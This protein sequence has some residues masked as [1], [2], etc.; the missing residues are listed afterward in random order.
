MIKIHATL[1]KKV[2]IPGLDYSSQSYGCGLE[3]EVSDGA[4]HEQIQ[5]RIRDTY[6]LLEGAIDAEIAARQ[7][8]PRGSPGNGRPGAGRFDNAG[9]GSRN[10]GGD[11]SKSKDDRPASKPQVKAI[12]AI[13]KA[14]DMSR[15]DLTK[16]LERDYQ[17]S[18]PE[19]LSMASA[20]KLIDYLNSLKTA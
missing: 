12:I 11:G 5:A 15:Q 16:L 9:S 3:V 14:I 20:S 8:A 17:K 4:T 18:V 13:C 2:P 19:D 10:N 6:G 1:S 7:G